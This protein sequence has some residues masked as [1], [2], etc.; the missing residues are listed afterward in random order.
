MKQKKKNFVPLVLLKD[1]TQVIRLTAKM[2]VN[3]NQS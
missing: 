2:Q 1:T 3:S